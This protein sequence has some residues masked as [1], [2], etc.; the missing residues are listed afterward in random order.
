LPNDDPDV[1]AETC[2]RSCAS[3]KIRIWDQ[4]N[5]DVELPVGQV[6]Q[7]GGRGASL[8]LGYFDD[9]IATEQSFNASGWFMT[10]DLGSLDQNGCLRIVGRKKDIILRGGHN[11]YPA[12]IEALA[13]R[14]PDI[15]KAAAFPVADARLGE[16]VCLAIVTRSGREVR[17]DA[18]LEHLDSLGLS[19]YEMPEYML[20]LDE[21]PLTATGKIT[22]RV[23]ARW[24]EEGRHTPLPVRHQRHVAA[25]CMRCGRSRSHNS[26]RS[27][28]Q[29]L[30]RRPIR[31]HSPAK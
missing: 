25:G 14:H 1:I 3:Y 17:T 21:L 22:K 24:V 28:P 29:A 23:L 18:L 10:G 2:G 12:R 6:G 19:H 7:I 26:G 13:L 31:S 4:D 15:D 9:Q 5:P 8:M 27:K 11:I 30:S 20:F 16:R